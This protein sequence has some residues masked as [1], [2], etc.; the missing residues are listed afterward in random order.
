SPLYRSAAVSS[1]GASIPSVGRSLHELGATEGSQRTRDWRYHAQRSAERI[2]EHYGR[3]GT[4]PA[5][6]RWRPGNL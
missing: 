5:A 4:T 2:G 6:K 3:H 1:V